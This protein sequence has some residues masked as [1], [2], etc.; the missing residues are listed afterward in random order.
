MRAWLDFPAIV[1]VHSALMF[2]VAWLIAVY[3][4]S[5]FVSCASG[6]RDDSNDIAHFIFAIIIGIMVFPIAFAFSF[7]SIFVIFH[8]TKLNAFVS[9]IDTTIIE[10]LSPF[11]VAV[12]IIIMIKWLHPKS[13]AI[14]A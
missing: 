7:Q 5:F 1:I 3:V 13:R 9:F 6:G 10:P 14:R 2:V 8:F 4:W 11:I 12:A